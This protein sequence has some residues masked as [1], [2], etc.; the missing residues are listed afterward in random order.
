M[1]K[2]SRP[3][4]DPTLL[5]PSQLGMGRYTAKHLKDWVFYASKTVEDICE[6]GQVEK[7]YYIWRFFT[8]KISNVHQC[9][10]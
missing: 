10:P 5:N 8:D 1:Q 7:I 6:C 4:A 3:D 9:R 2:L